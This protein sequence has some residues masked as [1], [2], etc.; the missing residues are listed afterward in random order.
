MAKKIHTE[1]EN[2]Y[3]S[4][5][6]MVTL[7]MIFF[8]YLFSISDINPVKLVKAAESMNKEIPNKSTSSLLS[9]NVQAIKKFEYEQKKLEKM[10]KEIQR[11]INEQDMQGKVAVEYKD[12]Q[13]DLNLGDAVLFEL[14]RSDLRKEALGILQK[15]ALM[16]QK[17]DSYITI[18]GHTDDIPI[19]S[20][21]YPSN[22]ELSAARAGS[23]ARYLQ[24]L[25][26]APT[27]FTVIGCSQYKPLVPNTSAGNQAKNRRVKITLK[28]DVQKMMTS[29]K[30]RHP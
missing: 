6:D 28:P 27:R 12:G 2:F 11:Y 20:T 25:A 30:T 7:L 23:V 24:V 21:V 18:E 1:V 29:S 19:Q 17:S 4:Y 26:I 14:G 10:Q 3:V 9:E 13:L 15:L 16:F 22:W 5:S 8:V